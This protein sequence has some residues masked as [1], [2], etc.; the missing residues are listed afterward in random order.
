M[1]ADALAAAKAFVEVVTL[2]HAG[3]RVAAGELNHAACAQS[4][5]PFA[6][7]ADFGA[8]GVK[9]FAGLLVV[10][11]RVDFDLLGRK[12]WACAVAPAGVANQG[13]EVANQ[14]DD[15]VPQVLQLAH[16]V[17]YNGVADVDVGRGGV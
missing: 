11:L 8:G 12:R 13:G 15:G 17:E 16:F 7:V 6:V 14:K 3:Y 10:G 2:H 5:A 1:H 9:H 4:V